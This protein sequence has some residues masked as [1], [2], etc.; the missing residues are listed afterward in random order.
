LK[1]EKSQ[2]GEKRDADLRVFTEDNSDDTEDKS[3]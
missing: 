3:D 1:K 2:N